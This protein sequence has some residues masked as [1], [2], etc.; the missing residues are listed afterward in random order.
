MPEE[1]NDDTRLD[2]LETLDKLI[3][4]SQDDYNEALTSL[5]RLKFNS[6]KYELLGP[7][8]FMVG[9]SG[10]LLVNDPK[11]ENQLKF[12]KNEDG[13]VIFEHPRDFTKDYEQNKDDADNE[14]E[15][16]DNDDFT[17]HSKFNTIEEFMEFVAEKEKNMKAGNF[18]KRV[19]SPEEMIDIRKREFVGTEKDQIDSASL[20]SFLGGKRD[21]RVE[22]L[23][24]QWKKVFEKYVE[25]GNFVNEV[26]VKYQEK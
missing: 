15:D 7:S 21:F 13:F 10:Y 11:N 17:F 12:E 20:F 6:T 14:V 19:Y 4:E 9:A 1:L 18:G 5:S 3:T 8:S 26:K 23:Q 24:R 25:L 16:C 22:A 2:D